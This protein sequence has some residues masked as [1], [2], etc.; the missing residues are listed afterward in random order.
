MRT[1]KDYIVFPLDVPSPEAARSL[2]NLLA[3]DV[4]MFKVGLELFIRSGPE[5]V[6]WIQQAG[7]AEVFLDLKL[8]DIPVTVKRAMA[9]VAELGVFLA[10]VHC[11]DSRTMLE[12]AVE[13]AGGR[14]NVLGVTV[15]TSVASTDLVEA[16]YRDCY[17]GDL[18]QLVMK[19]ARMAKNAGCSGVVC[20]GQEVQAI[21]AAFGNAFLTVTP[22]IRPSGGGVAADDQ[23][24]IVTPAMAIQGGADY[25]VI[26]RPIRDSADP[27]A[28]ARTIAAEIQ[29]ALNE[30]RS[31]G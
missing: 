23:S 2:V 29:E 11:G 9:R 12:A 8:H 15:L 10:T 22:G 27:R 5:L 6:R 26:G 13:G 1:G 16:G 19:K 20:S 7:A 3:D 14:V 17:A 24:R 25:L 4:G 30:Q 28:T 18:Q 21:R 31:Q